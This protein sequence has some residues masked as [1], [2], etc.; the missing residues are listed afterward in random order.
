[1]Y[2]QLQRASIQHD[3]LT[4]EQK[5]MVSGEEQ[6]K[7]ISSFEEAFMAI[8]EA[9]GVS[10]LQQVVLRFQSQGATT[11]HLNDLKESGEK[12]VLRLKEDKSKLQKEFEEMKY[13]GEAKLSR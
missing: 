3:D 11:R 10:D 9:T 13:S 5:Q 7:K 6:E 4:P 8:K 12:Q 1:M 2:I